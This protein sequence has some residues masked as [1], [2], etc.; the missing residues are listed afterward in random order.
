MCF[1]VI[2]LWA[3]K[4][5]VKVA[6]KIAI[7]I[8]LAIIIGGL[9][10]G[11]RKFIN[12]DLKKIPNNIETPQAMPSNAGVS[13]S[14]KSNEIIFAGLSGVPPRY[15][16]SGPDKGSGWIEYKTLEVRKGMK[17]DGFNFKVEYM[18]PAR[19]AHEFHVGNPICTFPVS[20][21]N[22]P[23]R[24]AKKPDRI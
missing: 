17:E 1:L 13:S 10:W 4:L 3:M 18:S 12:D 21:N 8:S 19:I 6:R 14:A 7:L 24:F 23:G 16:E 15:I 22:T 20:W 5:I 2:K 11:G 9:I